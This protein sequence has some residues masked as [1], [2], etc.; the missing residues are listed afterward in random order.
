MQNAQAVNNSETLDQASVAAPDAPEASVKAPKPKEYILLNDTGVIMPAASTLVDIFKAQGL[1]MEV[2]TNKDIKEND[3]EDAVFMKVALFVHDVPFKGLAGASL[4]AKFKSVTKSGEI[5]ASELANLLD[6]KFV[7]R[8][9]RNAQADPIK[10]V[11]SNG[12]L[13]SYAI[14]EMHEIKDL[15]SEVSFDENE[16]IDKE[17]FEKISKAK[18]KLGTLTYQV[19]VASGFGK[20]RGRGANKTETSET[21]ESLESEESDDK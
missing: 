5:S 14:N 19:G 11:A 10:W 12:A 20:K 6:R 21:Q 1:N 4:L 16:I 8:K 9:G 3:V 17:W 7:R 13:S 18:A 15:L 2:F